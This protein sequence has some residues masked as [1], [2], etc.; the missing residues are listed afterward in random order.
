MSDC[1]DMTAALARELTQGIRHEVENLSAVFK[2]MAILKPQTDLLQIAEVAEVVDTLPD[3]ILYVP[4][5]QL[6]AEATVLQRFQQFK[7]T[8][9]S[10]SLPNSV[11]LAMVESLIK[12]ESEKDAL[13]DNADV[14]DPFAEKAA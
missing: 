9:K 7:E 10:S 14:F 3:T 5:M 8:V 13:G 6:S 12:A 11:L 2:K 4:A 1:A